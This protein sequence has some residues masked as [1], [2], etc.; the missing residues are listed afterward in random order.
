MRPRCAEYLDIGE[1]LRVWNPDPVLDNNFNF[2]AL[3]RTKEKI[4]TV[5]FYSHLLVIVIEQIHV[6]VIAIVS[7]SK[8]KQS[9]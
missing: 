3:F 2:I 8:S 1:S 5:L 9:G 7:S 4:N 6:I